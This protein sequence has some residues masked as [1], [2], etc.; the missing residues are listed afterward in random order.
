[1]GRP[2]RTTS[3]LARPRTTAQLA[4]KGVVSVA[5]G[6][7]RS[8]ASATTRSS[9]TSARSS[10]SSRSARARATWAAARTSSPAT[11]STRSACR[12]RSRSS[13]AKNDT[14]G[15]W[16]SVD[17]RNVTTRER[18]GRPRLGS[19]Q[20][21]RA[22]A[23]RWSTRSSSR[24]ASRTSW[25]AL[26]A[27][28]RKQF[29]KYVLTPILARSSTSCTSWTR[30]TTN[31]DDLVAVL[32]TGVP[33][34]TSRARGR[35]HAPAEPSHPRDDEPEPAGR[36]RRA[37]T[38]VGRTAAA[39]VTTSSTSPSRSMAG[40]LKG[41]EGPARRRRERRRPEPAR[42]VPVRRGSAE[43]I[44]EHEGQV[45]TRRSGG[46]SG[47]APAN[48][49]ASSV[50]TS[51]REASLAV[52]LL[53]AR[54]AAGST[55]RPRLA[56]HP[57]GNFTVNRYAG[58]E[59]AGSDDLRPLRPR[60]R[61][62]P[63]V[64]ARRRGAEARVRGS[65]RT[66]ARAD[67]RRPTRAPRVVERRVELAPGRRR[68][69][70]APSRRRLPRAAGRAR[71]STS[72]T[73][74]FPGRI[75]WRE[76]TVGG[77]RRRASPRVR[78][79]R[80]SESQRRAPRVSGRSPALAARRLARDRRRRARASQPVRRPSIDEARTPQ[81]HGWRFR[82]AASSRAISRSACSCSRSSIA[83][84]WGAA[85]ALTPGHGKA[86][87]AAYLVG[88]KGT[89]RHAF[90]LGGTVTIAHTAGVFA[91]GFVTL[92]LSAFIVP[93]Q[94]YPWLTLVSGLLVVAVGASVLRQ[95]LRGV[96]ATAHSPSP[97]SHTATARAPPSPDH[98]HDDALTSKGI[99]GVGIAA[100]LL[101]CPS[102]L[103]V[104]LSAIAL[105]RVGLGLALIVAF[106]VGLAATITAIGLLAVLARRTFSRL[107]LERSGRS[108]SA[109]RQRGAHPRRR[110]RHHRPG[111]SRRP[112]SE[113]L[114][115]G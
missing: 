13:D 11:A 72:A 101:P 33:G 74:P 111:A 2:R 71:S 102:A 30:P 19:G 100:G 84:F 62:D 15:V 39:S 59:I 76:V 96:A 79:S 114:A 18:E 75:G 64:P 53:A 65:A 80:A 103:V 4:A 16:S 109:G 97:R 46:R 23:T 32:L 85:H 22:R 67:A 37:T 29:R 104:L 47:P 28:Q 69:R 89:P 95:R 24:P 112:L 35:G 94:L 49:S 3:A 83:A 108:R 105:H 14:I 55:P 92:G 58:I 57:L 98:D 77:T 91:L 63:D 78:R 90:L 73:R 48:R 44:R 81:S 60:P 113:P 88:T 20:V 52:A 99:L 54:R 66:R 17:R 41:N 26:R 82:G 1:M 68:A 50:R 31:R 86:M 70:D 21:Y 12:S 8:R 42:V 107:S 43:R 110:R 9:A 6:H 56:R 40:F 115:S 25:N 45:G 61:G 27:G 106:S 36:H 93:E 10:T 51:P 38:R 7:G 87:V 34:S 5:A